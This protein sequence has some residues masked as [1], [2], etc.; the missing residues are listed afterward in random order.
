VVDQLHQFKLSVCS[1]CVGD[2][3]EGSA[4]LLDSHVL[5]RHCVVGGTEIRQLLVQQLIRTVF[6][7][8]SVHF[9]TWKMMLKY[10]LRTICGR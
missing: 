9:F 10:S 6:N 8:Y 3:L 4:Q 2:I 5:L 7:E 1:L